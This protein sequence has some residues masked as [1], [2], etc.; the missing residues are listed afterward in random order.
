MKYPPVLG[1]FETMRLAAGGLSIARAG[2]GEA[3]VI[4]GSSYVRQRGSLTLATELF[5]VLNHPAPNCLPCIPTLDPRGPK[6]ENWLRHQARF[7][8]LLHRQGRWGSAFVTRPDSAPWIETP[9]YYELMLSCWQGKRAVLISEPNNKLVKLMQ[10]TAGELH[11]I[12]CPSEECY[13][14]I[15][16]FEQEVAALKP[17][18]AVLCLG[19]TATCLANRLAWRGVHALDLGS[20]GG[21]LARL[22]DL[23]S[24]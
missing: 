6:Y 5:N 9:A 17:Q 12:A 4:C 1:E 22:A 3:K 11:Y 21:M 8:T 18:V 13:P 7:E 19:V 24:R 15:D 14:L 16:A 2:D 23:E 20:V 10:R